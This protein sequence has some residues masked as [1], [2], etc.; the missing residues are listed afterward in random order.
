MKRCWIAA[1]SLISFFAFM[2]ACDSSGDDSAADPGSSSG[3][4]QFGSAV[5]DS[6][7]GTVQS[8]DGKV[9]VSFD[10]GVLDEETPVS[11][12]S[13]SGDHSDLLTDLYT[14]EPSGMT[15]DSP[16]SINFILD[17]EYET[18]SVAVARFDSG[19]PEV[20]DNSSHW[21][22]AVRV[23]LNSFSTY[24]AV[25]VSS[26]PELTDRCE[27]VTVGGKPCNDENADE[28]CTKFPDLPGTSEAA[29]DS[30]IDFVPDYLCVCEQGDATFGNM[31]ACWNEQCQG[32]GPPCRQACENA[33]M[34]EWTGDCYHPTLE[35]YKAASR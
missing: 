7:G 1:L 27:E 9:R 33:D 20:L 13:Q 2:A 3:A 32:P 18:G 6:S 19:S 31:R 4:P 30:S 28:A 34:G 5:I 11:I 26:S 25:S 35:E 14:L 22:N 10:E 17:K 29:F 21:G 24:G 23:E 12:E 16:V 15:F 8:N